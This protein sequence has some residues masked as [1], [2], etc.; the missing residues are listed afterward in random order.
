[1][2][3]PYS[4]DLEVNTLLSRHFGDESARTLEGWKKLGG[5]ASLPKAL[6]MDPDD[7]TAVVK[8][9]GLRGRGG[10]GFP[11]GVK[12]SFMPKESKKPHYLVVNADEGEPGTFKDRTIMERNPHSLIEGCIIGAYAIALGFF[13]IAEGG[14]KAAL[15]RGLPEA[16]EPA[17]ADRTPPCNAPGDLV[18]A[19]AP[20]CS[21]CS[22]RQ[23]APRAGVASRLL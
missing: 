5:Y 1:M 11:T 12:W 21:T 20:A 15:D 19:I 10:A 22:R 4:H 18:D 23:V 17:R 2:G 8:D 7:I 14:L 13:V 9:S 3:Y 16:E 6:E